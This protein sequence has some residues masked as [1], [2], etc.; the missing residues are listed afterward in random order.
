[1]NP[2]RRFALWLG[3]TG[4]GRKAVAEGADIRIFKSKPTPKVYIGFSLMVLSYPLSF[5]GLAFCGYLA[6]N[7]SEPLI[8]VIGGG[9]VVVVV[10]LIFIAGAYLAGANYLKVM[11]IWGVGKFLNR[12]P[13][14]PVGDEEK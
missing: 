6:L 12:Y 8:M 5:A 3:G 9:A 10:H 1:M 4:F 2:A 7:R 11:L 14:D 13:P